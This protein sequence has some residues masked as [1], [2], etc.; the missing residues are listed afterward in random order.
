MSTP[1][2]A[3]IASAFSIPA[4][5]ST[6]I[7]TIVCASSA[8]FS[9]AAGVG[10]VPSPGTIAIADR[11]PRGGKRAAATIASASATVST[12]GATIPWAPPSSNRPTIP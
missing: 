4:G 10:R 5:V 8:G 7:C 3:A 11:C 6:M 9:V 1:S 2:S 12:R